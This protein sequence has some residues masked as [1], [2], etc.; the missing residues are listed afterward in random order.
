MIINLKK[1]EEKKGIRWLLT[2]PAPTQAKFQNYK[3][4]DTYNSLKDKL[5]IAFNI[6]SEHY[7]YYFLFTFLSLS[8]FLISF[9]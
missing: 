8:L 9:W 4:E 6:S 2:L 7:Y 3:T 1:K 5:Y